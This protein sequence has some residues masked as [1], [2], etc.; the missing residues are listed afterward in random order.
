MLTNDNTEDATFRLWP[1]CISLTKISTRWR[2]TKSCTTMTQ[3]SL[4]RTIPKQITAGHPGKSR[5]FQTTRTEFCWPFVASD[6]IH[7]MKNCQTCLKSKVLR[8]TRQQKLR[9]FPP[10]RTLQ[11][12]AVDILAP[13]P[14]T[15]NDNLHFVIITDLYTKMTREVLMRKLTS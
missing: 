15:E 1:Q 10:R 12:I 6:L 9:L 3:R 8:F 5:L 14:E 7:H 4:H 11:D 2:A 13:L